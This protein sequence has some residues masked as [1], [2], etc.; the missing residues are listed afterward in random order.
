MWAVRKGADTEHDSRLANG[1]LV[2]GR[3]TRYLIIDDLIASGDTVNRIVKHI[4]KVS[5]CMNLVGGFTQMSEPVGVLTYAAKYHY[6]FALED[7]RKL[8][9]FHIR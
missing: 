4:S 8:P 1:F 6:E 2:K 9:T 3:V 7:G 5:N